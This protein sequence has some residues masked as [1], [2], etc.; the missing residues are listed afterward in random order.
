MSNPAPLF[1]RPMF[2][3]G[4]TRGGPWNKTSSASHLNERRRKC[5]KEV[6][7]WDRRRRQPTKACEDSF[8]CGSWNLILLKKMKEPVQNMCS[9][10]IPPEGQG[11]WGIYAPSPVW[12]SQFR[13]YAPDLSHL[14]GKG[15]EVFMLRLLFDGAS[16][17]HM[18][19]TYPTWGARELGYLCSDSC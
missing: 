16:S 10:L 9:W 2:S 1:H 5:W 12:R 7:R 18:L 11:S 3:F 17:E 19:L 15:A 8:S 4:V 6:G 13:T 14:R